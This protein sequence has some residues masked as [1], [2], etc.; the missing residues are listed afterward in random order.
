ME[1][2]Q[3][4]FAKKLAELEEMLSKLNGS[5]DSAITDD[6]LKRLEKVEKKAKKAKDGVK[7]LEKKYK[8]WKPK[9]KEMEKDIDYLKN[10]LKDKTDQSVFT[11]EMDRLK[12][13][14]N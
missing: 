6:F 10:A 8:K 14:I 5:G 9:W 1:D 7:K 11:D 12:D 13:L 4:E 2:K 3:D